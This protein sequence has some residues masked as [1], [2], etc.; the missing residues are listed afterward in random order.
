MLVPYTS[1]RGIALASVRTPTNGRS[2]RLRPLSSYFALRARKSLSAEVRK[3]P[4]RKHM[5]LAIQYI[6][7]KTYSI[8]IYELLLLITLSSLIILVEKLFTSEGLELLKEADIVFVHETHVC[9]FIF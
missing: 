5:S 2:A 6:F 4:S 9:N 7:S 8:F 1:S 3:A